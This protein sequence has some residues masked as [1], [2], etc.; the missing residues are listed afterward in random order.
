MTP[1]ATFSP[2]MP[3]V[4]RRLPLYVAGTV[5][6]TAALLAGLLVLV[7]DPAWWRGYVAATVVSALAATASLLPL[8]WGVRH[9]LMHAVAGYFI[10]AGVRATI[11]LGGCALAVIKGGYPRTPTMLLMVAFYFAVL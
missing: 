10:A 3:D 5:V 8:L 7:N 11:S 6:G 4:T 2:T 9:G 1:T